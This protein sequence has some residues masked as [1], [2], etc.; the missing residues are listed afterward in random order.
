[1]PWCPD[2]KD[3]YED[4]VRICADCGAT[5]VNEDELLLSNKNKARVA[6]ALPIKEEPEE[7]VQEVYLMHIRNRVELSYMISMLEEAG[8][9][10]RVLK[11]RSARNLSETFGNKNPD[12]RINVDVR[13]LQEAKE[14]AAS[15]SARPIMDEAVEEIKPEPEEYHFPRRA[16]GIRWWITPAGIITLFGLLVALAVLFG[17]KYS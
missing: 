1:M 12:I 13:R 11:G 2:C 7:P 5:L 9:A 10:Y 6:A 3:E 15:L 17:L 14:I 8:I 4:G 16:V